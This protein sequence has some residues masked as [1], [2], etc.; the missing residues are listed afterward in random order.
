MTDLENRLEEIKAKITAYFDCEG[1]R[2]VGGV[3]WDLV[4]VSHREMQR[5]FLERHRV[6]D[7]YRIS[8]WH[9]YKLIPGRPTLDQIQAV[10]RGLENAVEEVVRPGFQQM[11]TQLIGVV[12]TH[13]LPDEPV[14]A[15][16]KKYRKRRQFW[17]GLKGWVILQMA[18]TAV[19]DEKIVL[20]KSLKS[21]RSLLEMD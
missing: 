14:A 8:E 12:V 2:T 15:S 20:R 9:F 13:H 10:Q 19:S 11:E 3:F 18:L 7:K 16:I 6:V 1:A 4:A 21:F 5:Y 17:L